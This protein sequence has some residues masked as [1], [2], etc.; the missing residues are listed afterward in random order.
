M[1]HHDERTVARGSEVD[2]ALRN[3][4]LFAS[5]TDTQ[6]A[7]VRDTG[8]VIFARAGSTLIRQGDTARGMSVIVDGTV[9][10]D[11]PLPDGTR[12]TLAHLETGDVFGELSLLDRLPRSAD[13]VAATDAR[14]FL[15]DGA[16]FDK[17]RQH[18]RGAVYCILRGIAPVLGRRVRTVDDLIAQRLATKP[19]RT[20]S[21]ISAPQI[22]PETD[23]DSAT[24]ISAPLVEDASSADAGPMTEP[25]EALPPPPSLP[26]DALETT[27]EDEEEILPLGEGVDP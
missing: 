27:P 5:M 21:G 24:V 14:I 15:I 13:A 3:M 25:A 19:A 20:V 4:P 6:Y 11:L 17:L 18:S 2:A 16:E 1:D 26:S 9:R 22:A 8:K 12:T 7:A 23:A 10:V